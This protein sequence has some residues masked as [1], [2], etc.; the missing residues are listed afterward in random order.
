MKKRG[1]LAWALLFLS[2]CSCAAFAQSPFVR[3][4]YIPEYYPTVEEAM[5]RLKNIQPLLMSIDDGMLKSVEADRF[6][7][8]FFWTVG[9]GNRNPFRH[10]HGFEDL[11]VSP[12]KWTV[13]THEYLPVS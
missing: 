6:G 9:P 7:I 11:A 12:E 8:R 3:H 1:L 2:L 13:K 10:A 4:Y 5:G